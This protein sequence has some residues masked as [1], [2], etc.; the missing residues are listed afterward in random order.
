MSTGTPWRRSLFAREDGDGRRAILVD[1]AAVHA[2]RVERRGD[3]AVSIHRDDAAGILFLLWQLRHD[4]VRGS[5]L[6]R[7]LRVLHACADVVGDGVADEVLA[8]SSP[9]D[10]ASRVG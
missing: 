8:P 7:R 2:G 10:G 4:D 1:P 5:S 3:A 6:D 9:G